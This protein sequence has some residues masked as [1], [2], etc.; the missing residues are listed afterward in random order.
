[1]KHMSFRSAALAIPILMLLV[2]A[3]PGSAV[4][5]ERRTDDL[6][7]GVAE[8][9]NGVGFFDPAINWPSSP[10]LYYYV[11]NGPPNTCGDLH[12]QRN[13]G[14]W[15]VTPGWLCTNG[16]GFAQK[17]P[18]LWSSQTGDETAEA[19]VQWP[20]GTETTH[21]WHIWDVN[22]PSVS[23]DASCLG[24][25]PSCWRGTA[26]DPPFGACF[27]PSWS[28]VWSYFLNVTTGGYWSSVTDSYA[29]PQTAF[30]GP[31]STL[32]SCT[33]P[34]STPFPSWYAHTQ[35]HTYRWTVC[36]WDGGQS[37]C[38]DHFFTY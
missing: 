1:M 5:P 36:V 17:G 24:S 21:D 11:N 27:H 18:W 20:N 8:Q 34:W 25:P 30:Y 2:S 6:P 16:T 22:P 15:Q 32:T 37:G 13:N 7:G 9:A 38:T 29:H 4:P 3:S 23:L 28:Y 19:Y 12:I 31:S 33:P 10:P 26:S 14:S 35:G